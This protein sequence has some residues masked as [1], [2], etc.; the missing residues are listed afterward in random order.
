VTLTILA[1]I[2]LALILFVALIGFKAVIKQGKPPE[3]LNS[4]RCSVCR[5]KFHK[6]MLVERQVGDYKILFFCTSCISS[7]HNEMVSKN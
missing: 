6:S 7:L 4:E 1:A 2:F 3:E 5:E